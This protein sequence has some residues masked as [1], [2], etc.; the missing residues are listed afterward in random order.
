MRTYSSVSLFG[1]YKSSFQF[2]YW[3]DGKLY[4][5]NMVPFSMQIYK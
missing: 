3:D 2:V 5:F 4:V 1:T